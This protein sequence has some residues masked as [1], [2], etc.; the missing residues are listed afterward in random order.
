MSSERTQRTRPS[1]TRAEAPLEPAST[2]NHTSIV[3]VVERGSGHSMGGP[4]MIC[5]TCHALKRYFSTRWR[6]QSATP[7]VG[8]AMMPFL[9]HNDIP[10]DWCIVKLVASQPPFLIPTVPAAFEPDLVVG[11]RAAFLVTDHPRQFISAKVVY[12]G[13]NKRGERGYV[14]LTE[15]GLTVR[16]CKG[17]YPRSDG[18]P[19]TF[20]D[21]CTFG[22]EAH[23]ARN[24]A[25]HRQKYPRQILPRPPSRP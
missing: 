24:I 18:G 22:L 8:A 11:Q 14:A 2:C 9:P 13:E 12:F 15:Q 6:K 16:G 5:R 25:A 23:L 7:A 10:A 19:E 17:V 21:A 3:R 20:W 4:T 1:L